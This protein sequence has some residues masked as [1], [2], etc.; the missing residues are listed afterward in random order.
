[1]GYTGWCE[2]CIV[3]AQDTIE[4]DALADGETIEPDELYEAANA[5]IRMYGPLCPTCTL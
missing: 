5:Y 3:R 2:H 4:G 1:M